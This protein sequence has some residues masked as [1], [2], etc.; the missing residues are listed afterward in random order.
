MKNYISK[1]YLK[2]GCTKILYDC[3]FLVLI[4]SIYLGTMELYKSLNIIIMV[5]AS[6]SISLL[7]LFINYF[8]IKKGYHE[9]IFRVS[10]ILT[11]LFICTLSFFT[12]LGIRTGVFTK[13]LIS[14]FICMFIVLSLASLFFLKKGWS[15]YKTLILLPTP[16]W[17]WLLIMAFFGA[18]P[19]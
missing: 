8:A 9:I 19:D 16:P 18:F 6:I 7:C 1:D 3:F 4:T 11:I 12:Y 5:I 10:A 15:E 13:E 14:Y 2:Y 17:I